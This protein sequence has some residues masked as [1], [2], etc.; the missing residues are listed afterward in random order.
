ML[1]QHSVRA[2]GPVSRCRLPARFTHGVHVSGRD[3]GNG[4]ASGGDGGSGK[5]EYA[6]DGE[7]RWCRHREG[8]RRGGGGNGGGGVA[9]GQGRVGVA[10][11]RPRG[12]CCCC[13]RRCR[14]RH[15]TATTRGSTPRIPGPWR[16]P[17]GAGCTTYTRNEATKLH[18]RTAKE[19][20]H[21]RQTEAQIGARRQR[22]RRFEAQGYMCEQGPRRG[23]S[24][25]R[26]EGA[27]G[28][29]DAHISRA[30]SLRRGDRFALHARSSLAT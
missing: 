14:R 30:L 26:G 16:G 18:A 17:G 8:W 21:A 15:S 22:R 1:P 23:G 10:G 4:G 12:Y 5:N 6:G 7:R 11:G 2:P 29:S 20:A 3:G 28:A 24:H 27:C 25:G 9:S 19:N 13:H